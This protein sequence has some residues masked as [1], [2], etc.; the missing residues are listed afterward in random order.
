MTSARPHEL[1]IYMTNFENQS[2]YAHYDNIVVDGENEQYALRE[3]GVYSGTAGDSMRDNEHQKFSTLDRDNDGSQLDC[4]QVC[5]GGWWYNNCGLSNLNGQYSKADEY[6][7]SSE[8]G[9]YWDEWLGPG[10]TMQSVQMLIR[11][12]IN[13]EK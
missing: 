7:D 3:L 9:I 4:A 1:Y 13:T 5:L 8:H 6:Y 10:F 11:P 2:S 12:K